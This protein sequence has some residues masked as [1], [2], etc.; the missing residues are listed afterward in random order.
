MDDDFDGGAVPGEGLID[1][2]IDNFLHHM[3]QSRT[4]VRI[5]DVHAGALANRL[6]ALQYL[7]RASVVLVS[8]V[9]LV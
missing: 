8:V 9:T 4:V 1:R 3:V 6:Q 5:A 2:V 7:N